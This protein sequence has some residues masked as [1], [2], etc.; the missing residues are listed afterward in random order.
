MT[1]ALTK[2][3]PRKRSGRSGSLRSGKRV[4]WGI[5]RCVQTSTL[6]AESHAQKVSGC[7]ALA[8][9]LIAYAKIVESVELET[10]LKAVEAI[11]GGGEHPR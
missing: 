8:Q 3:P 1:T 4:L 7:H 5:I 2:E 11:V 10:R 6:A 9:S